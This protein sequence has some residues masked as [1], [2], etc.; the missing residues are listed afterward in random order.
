EIDFFKDFENA[1][2]S[3]VPELSLS[4]GIEWDRA[5]ASVSEVSGALKRSVEK[6]RAAE[7]MATL[8]SVVDPTF[9]DAQ[10]AARDRAQIDMGVY[11]EHAFDE[12]PGVGASERLAFERRVASEVGSY[13][14]AL[15]DGGKSALGAMIEKP[16]D[17]TRMFVMNPLGWPRSDVAD[18]AYPGSG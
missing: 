14:D 18:L 6:L 12:G 5:P 7:A 8:A 17:K 4:F 13:V 16:A 15:Y 9:G 11:F 1:Y 10:Q 3:V 2:G